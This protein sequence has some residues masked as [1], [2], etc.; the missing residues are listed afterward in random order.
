MKKRTAKRKTESIKVRVKQED[1]E[2]LR[3]HCEALGISESEGMRLAL[4]DWVKLQAEKD[5]KPGQR[6]GSASAAMRFPSAR[7]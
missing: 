2:E 6:W 4:I 1:R 7:S 5:G 3:R